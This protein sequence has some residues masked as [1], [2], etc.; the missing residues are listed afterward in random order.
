MIS[1]PPR[2][3]RLLPCLLYRWCCPTPAHQD[4]GRHYMS[5]T[6]RRRL[7]IPKRRSK[8]DHMLALVRLPHD[9]DRAAS[10]AHDGHAHRK[11]PANGFRYDARRPI[12]DRMTGQAVLTVRVVPPGVV[13]SNGWGGRGVI[14]RR[15]ATARPSTS[16]SAPPPPRLCLRRGQPTRR[17]RRRQRV[18]RRPT[19]PP[20][21]ALTRIEVPA[22]RPGP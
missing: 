1:G 6:D 5:A 8:N 17:Q 11:A 4:S 18:P 16:T 21:P 2:R 19:P 15:R 3:P 10:G 22:A 14:V 20:R 12:G 9:S 7:N 13:P